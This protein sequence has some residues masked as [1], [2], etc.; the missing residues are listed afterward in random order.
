VLAAIHQVPNQ[1][2]EKL[3]AFP[4]N[5]IVYH[6]LSCFILFFQIVIMHVV[7]V[8]QFKLKL[9]LLENCVKALEFLVIHCFAR[10]KQVQILA[11][12]VDKM[13]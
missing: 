2:T 1:V 12:R 13:R 11:D 10:I 8:K 6:Q 9:I 3:Q 5:L 7:Q 4:F